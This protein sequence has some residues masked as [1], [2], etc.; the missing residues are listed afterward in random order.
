MAEL[1]M[2]TLVWAK[3]FASLSADWGAA[4]CAHGAVAA[5]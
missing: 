1:D 3:G 2:Q 5:T 4:S